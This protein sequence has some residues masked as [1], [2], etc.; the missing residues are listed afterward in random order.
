MTIHMYVAAIYNDNALS[1]GDFH[2]LMEFTNLE[3]YNLFS[4]NVEE[5][6]EQHT[7]TI[8]AGFMLRSP[9]SRITPTY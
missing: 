3:F 1:A 6:Y 5:K 2:S 4:T 9:R 7:D 8:A